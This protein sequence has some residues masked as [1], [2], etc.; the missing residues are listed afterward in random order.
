[1]SASGAAQNVA[2]CRLGAETLGDR[3]AVAAEHQLTS[4]R[5]I[6]TWTARYMLM[7]GAGFAG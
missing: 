2:A 5:G 6:G 4:I 7:R 3:S 1:M